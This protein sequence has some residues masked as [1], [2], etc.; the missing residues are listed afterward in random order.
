MEMEESSSKSFISDLQN[1]LLALKTKV[2]QVSEAKHKLD[3]VREIFLGL[4]SGINL[5]RQKYEKKYWVMCKED[6]RNNV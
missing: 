2:C 1:L 5:S 3:K 4:I 6:L